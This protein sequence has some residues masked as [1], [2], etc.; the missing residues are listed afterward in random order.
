MKLPIANGRL[1]IEKS[2]NRIARLPIS[3][4]QSTISDSP[5]RRGWSLVEVMVVVTVM[6]V[7]ISMSVPSFQRSLEQSRA[8]I[9]GAN[10]RAVWSAERLYW[11]ENRTYTNDL[12]ELQSLGVLDPSIASATNWYV[13][14]IGAADAASFTATATRTGSSV[15]TGQ[16]SIDET[17]TVSGV[18]QASGEPDIVPGFQ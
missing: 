13:F 18:V 7:L 17:G 16:F 5:R 10:L 4:P 2:V 11:L 3:N 15:R 8:D 14:A 12:T 6:S 9:A 1:L